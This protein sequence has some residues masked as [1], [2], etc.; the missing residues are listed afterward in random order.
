MPILL[1]IVVKNKIPPLIL[2]S[3]TKDGLERTKI[4]FCQ[5]S[6]LRDEDQII[7][8]ISYETHKI[9]LN[10]MLVIM[11]KIIPDMIIIHFDVN[12]SL[13]DFIS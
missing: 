5:K 6:D 10:V 9:I 8:M 4:R 2:I 1:Y 12:H 13:Y 7:D 11:N 3:S